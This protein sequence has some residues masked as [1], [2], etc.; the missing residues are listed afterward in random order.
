MK[1]CVLSLCMCNSFFHCATIDISHTSSSMRKL[2]QDLGSTIAP[3]H[4]SILKRLLQSLLRSLSHE[5]LSALLLA[6]AA[7]FRILVQPLASTPI[8][9]T[10][11]LHDIGNTW[12]SLCEVLPSC[13]AEIQRAM[14]EVWSTIMRQ[15][16]VD[17]LPFCVRLMFDTSTKPGLFDVLAWVFLSAM[18]VS[19][20]YGL[21]KCH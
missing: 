5:S 4:N 18:K 20:R 10:A 17:C 6:C 7:L 3:F 19:G 11:Q 1:Q 13:S 2:C 21:R 9:A 12:S 15:L 14:A 8:A 16:E